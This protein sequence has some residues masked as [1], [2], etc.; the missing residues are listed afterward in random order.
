[1]FAQDAR[2]FNIPEEVFGPCAC[3]S[4]LQGKKLDVIGLYNED[5]CFFIEDIDLAFCEPVQ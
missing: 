3:G 4:H 5:F 1:M 2:T